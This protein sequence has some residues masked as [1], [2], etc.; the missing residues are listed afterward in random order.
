MTYP[1]LNRLFPVIDDLYLEQPMASDLPTER[2]FLFVGVTL[3]N[4][5]RFYGLAL[6]F[7]QVE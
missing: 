4:T 7:P 2:L 6:I 5:R 1:H 3:R